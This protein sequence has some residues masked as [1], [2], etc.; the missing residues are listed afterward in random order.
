MSHDITRQHTDLGKATVA[1][2]SRALA[3]PP[4]E[5][6]HRPTNRRRGVA[7]DAGKPSPPFLSAHS[8]ADRPVGYGAGGHGGV[9]VASLSATVR[10]GQHE[11]RRALRHP[12]GDRMTVTAPFVVT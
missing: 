1:R 7:R 6:T 5:P 12:S 10:E 3:P 8:S 9:V 4:L 11:V 2:E